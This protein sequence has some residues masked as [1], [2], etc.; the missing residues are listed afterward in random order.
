MSLPAQLFHQLNLGPRFVN[1]RNSTL[2]VPEFSNLSFRDQQLDL[3]RLFVEWYNSAL[4]DPEFSNLSFRDQQLELDRIVIVLNDRQQE[5][6]ESQSDED[7]EDDAANW[8]A[9]YTDNY[10]CEDWED[11]A[12]RYNNAHLDAVRESRD[13]S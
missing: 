11:D 7:W 6:Y 12:T 5:H 4:Q 3:D 1:W 9:H 13:G 10:D 8:I 2:Q